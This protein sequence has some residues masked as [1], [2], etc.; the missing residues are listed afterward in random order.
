MIAKYLKGMGC[1]VFFLILCSCQSNSPDGQLKGRVSLWHS[2]TPEEA[3]ILEEVLDQFKE[4]HPDVQIITTA[5]PYDQILPE[6]M[7]RVTSDLYYTL[8][9]VFTKNNIEIPN[10]Q[11]DINLGDG[12]RKLATPMEP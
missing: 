4:I 2:W 7:G 11:R 12:W 10:P 5:F 1:L 3:L 6:L 8:W 9:E